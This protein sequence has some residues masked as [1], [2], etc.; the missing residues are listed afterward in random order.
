MIY[1]QYEIY[2]ISSWNMI[3]INILMIFGI[4]EKWIILTHTMYCWLLLQIYLCYLWL[5]L[6]SRVTYCIC[7]KR[8]GDYKRQRPRQIHLSSFINWYLSS[9]SSM[10]VFMYVCVCVCVCARSCW[11]Q[12]HPHSEPATQNKHVKLYM[13]LED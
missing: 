7:L 1:L 6:C 8:C 10:W 5:L 2:K 4:K 3:F 13:T 11:T 9:S 12:Q